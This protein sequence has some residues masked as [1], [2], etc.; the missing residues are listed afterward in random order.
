MNREFDFYRLEDRV[1]LSGEGMEGA[2]AEGVDDAALMDAL[3]AEATDVGGEAASSQTGLQVADDG[4]IIDSEQVLIST[5]SQIDLTQPL[6]VVFVDEGVQ[7]RDVLVQDLVTN[8]DAEVQW[9]VVELSSEADGIAQVT[10]VLSQLSGVDA[11]H[12][13][14]HGDGNGIQLG[15]TQLDLATAEG[16]AGEIALWADALDAEGDLLIYGCDLASTEDGQTLIESLGALCDC[17][18]AASDDATGHEELGGDWHFEYIVGQ[19]DTDVAFSVDVQQN[20]NGTLASVTVTTLDDVVD[21]TASSVADLVNDPGADGLISL[22]EAIIASNANADADV[23]YL[24]AGVHTL[25]ISNLDI[26]ADVQI[27]G[28]ANGLSLIHISEPTR[29]Y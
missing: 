15:D 4:T 13:V 11:V 8:G 20:W 2:I 28:L 7:D 25:S 9:L 18:V 26:N 14:S 29:P 3:M 17:D 27:I 6:Q 24:G 5:I 23:I 10:S 12:I 16:R 22:R 21:R 19:V 1:L